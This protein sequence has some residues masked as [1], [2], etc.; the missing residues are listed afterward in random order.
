M[1][2]ALRTETV[3]DGFNGTPDVKQD[4]RYW[5]VGSDRPDYC[6]AG[7]TLAEAKLNYWEGLARTLL[8]RVKRGLP[9]DTRKPS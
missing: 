7:M 8:E 4:G 9:M 5:I 1:S 6:A 3:I 2:D